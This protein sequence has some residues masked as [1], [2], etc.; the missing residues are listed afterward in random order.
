MFSAGELVFLR[1]ISLLEIRA[2]AR[3]FN[4]KRSLVKATELI[5]SEEEKITNFPGVQGGLELLD[6][7]VQTRGFPKAYTSKELG[8]EKLAVLEWLGD[9]FG[10]H[11]RGAWWCMRLFLKGEKAP[12]GSIPE[13]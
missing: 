7:Y 5:R 2:R 6:L 12:Y 9:N 4:Q 3:A 10:R 1:E 8:L 11:K 13:D